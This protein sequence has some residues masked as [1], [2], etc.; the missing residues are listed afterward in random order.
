[1]QKWFH[2]QMQKLFR[3]QMEN[4]CLYDAV[5][6]YI[7]ASIKTECKNSSSLPIQS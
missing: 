3:V 7:Q 6:F 5:V 4:Q 2:V 1:M